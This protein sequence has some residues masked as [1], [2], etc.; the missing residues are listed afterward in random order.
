MRLDI[1]NFKFDGAGGGISGFIQAALNLQRNGKIIMGFGVIGVQ[2]DDMT[3]SGFG[4]P[5]AAQ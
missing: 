4:F 5:R 3:A 1:I 2:G